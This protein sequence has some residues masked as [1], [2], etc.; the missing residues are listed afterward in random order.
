M[1]SALLTD[2]DGFITE[3]T[4][5]NFFIAKDGELFTP[6]PRNILRGVTRQTVME[7]AADLG[8][9]CRERNLE[10]YDVAGADE[11]FN[12]STTIAVMPVT[13]FN[14]LPIGDGKVGP[15]VRSLIDAF[16]ELVA[17]DIVAQAKQYK[18]EAGE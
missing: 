6:E 5:N 10:P 11:A 16:S 4:G 7:L 17:V 15:M 9:R 2:D 14:G 1:A 12:T 13:R 8:I 18:E 3:G